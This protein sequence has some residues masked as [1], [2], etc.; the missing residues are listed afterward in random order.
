MP[1]SEGSGVLKLQRVHAQGV[2]EPPPGLWSNCMRAGDQVFIAGMVAMDDRGAVIAPG[3]SLRQAEHIFTTIRR[4]MESAGGAMSDIATMTIF[5][6]DMK[7]RPGVLE[8]RRKY[9]TG[10]FPCSTLVA[11]SALI[12]P[13]LVVEINAMGFI[14]AGPRE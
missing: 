9:F 13:G 14:G 10:D 2:S 7:L 6:T 8:A 4:Y 1:E 12:D 3:D 11:V 5:V